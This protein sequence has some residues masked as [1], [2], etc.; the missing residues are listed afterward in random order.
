MF[1]LVEEALVC[2]HSQH[3]V[4]IV[5]DLSF[6]QLSELSLNLFEFVIPHQLRQLAQI[7]LIQFF[8]L[9]YALLL[10]NL[11]RFDFCFLEVQFLSD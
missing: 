7:R 8:C 10:I 4:S 11:S 9:M 2:F 6:V 5:D 1:Y 3:S